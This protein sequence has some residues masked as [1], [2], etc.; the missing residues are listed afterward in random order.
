M[1]ILCIGGKKIDTKTKQVMNNKATFNERFA[2]KTILDFNVFEDDYE[3]KPVS[4]YFIYFYTPLIKLKVNIFI[5][6]KF[7][8]TFICN[9]Y[10]FVLIL[11]KRIKIFIII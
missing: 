11:C 2:M 8:I 3:P 9:Y 4:Y 6:Q 1:Y 5:F 10:F 7:Y